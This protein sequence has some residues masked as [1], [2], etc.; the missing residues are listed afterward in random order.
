MIVTFEEQYF[1]DLYENMD[2]SILT[3]CNVVDLSNHYK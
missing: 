3:I 2:E 1:E